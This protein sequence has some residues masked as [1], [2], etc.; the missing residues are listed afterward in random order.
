MQTLESSTVASGD[1]A[2]DVAPRDGHR[3]RVIKLSR[4]LHA[5]FKLLAGLVVSARNE[6]CLLIQTLAEEIVFLESLHPIKI[7][8][9]AW[10]DATRSACSRATISL[11]GVSRGSLSRLSLDRDV[12]AYTYWFGIALFLR[13]RERRAQ[14][15]LRG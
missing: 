4:R 2:L 1:N 7:F 10:P 11:A 5:L 3:L 9:P 15:P 6:C 13:L 14:A 8:D 12:P